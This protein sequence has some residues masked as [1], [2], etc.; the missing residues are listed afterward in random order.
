MRTALAIL[1][2]CILSTAFADPATYEVELSE[3]YRQERLDWSIS[4]PHGKPNIVSELKF[5]HVD[6]YV[7][8]LAV[9][10]TK[11]DYFL[12]GIASYGHIFHGRFID[13]DYEKSNRKGLFSHSTHSLKGDYTADGALLFGK[14]FTLDEGFTVSPQIGYGAYTQKYRIHQGTGKMRYFSFGRTHKTKFHGLNSTFKSNW[15]APEIG[16]EVKKSLTKTVNI[17]ASYT[18]LYPLKYDGKGYWNLREKKSRHFHFKN[19]SSKSYGNLAGLGVEWAFL[20][21]WSV[22][23]DYQFKKFYSRGGHESN[24]HHRVPLNKAHYTA[25]EV[26]LTLAYSF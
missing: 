26:R 15:Y 9:T 13:N 10:L 17:F 4:G 8:R 18:L 11:D 7:T 21:D 6:V 1:F 12:K 3:G 16:I 25:N 2:S 14:H 20:Q 22:K 23:V 5:K 24:P 19:K